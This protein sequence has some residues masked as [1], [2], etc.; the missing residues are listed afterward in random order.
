MPEPTKQRFPTWWQALILL[1]GGLV[2]GF[3]SCGAAL[4]SG[5]GGRPSSF[6]SLFVVGFFVGAAGFVGG[7]VLVVFLGL[8]AVFSPLGAEQ[9]PAPAPVGQPHPVVSRAATPQLF[10]QPLHAAKVKPDENSSLLAFRFAVILAI[11]FLAWNTFSR[12]GFYRQL[13]LPIWPYFV[14]FLLVNVPYAIA[15]VRTRKDADT[16]GISLA[17]A[18]AIISL[19]ESF[20]SFDTFVLRMPISRTWWEYLPFLIDGAILVSAYRSRTGVWRSGSSWG[21]LLVLVIGLIFYFALIFL[22]MRA[23]R[24]F[25]GLNRWIP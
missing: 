15:L 19:W 2:L 22:L 18:V 6:G 25:Y 5:F 10:P 1:F 12:L 7:V 3:T 13:H 16:V 20:S 21:R 17:A 8:R 24:A 23:N 4:S 9:I 14:G 11:A